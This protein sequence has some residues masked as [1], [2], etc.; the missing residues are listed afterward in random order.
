MKG[1]TLLAAVVMCWSC[2]KEAPHPATP[3]SAQPSLTLAQLDTMRQDSI[4]ALEARR[5]EDS[6][7]TAAAQ[8]A[9][10]SFQSTAAAIAVLDSLIA[11][12]PKDPET[13]QRLFELAKLKEHLV[14]FLD[15]SGRNSDDPY[16]KAHDADF[17]WDEP[18]GGFLYSGRDWERI[19]EEFP[20]SGVADTA[21]WILAHE[22][23]GGEC[24]MDFWCYYDGGT[25]HLFE[26]LRGFP[27]SSYAPRAEKEIVANLRYVLDSLP[28]EMKEAGDRSSV[29]AT[30][31]SMIAKFETSTSGLAPGIRNVLTPVTD[32]L[33]KHFG[34]RPAHD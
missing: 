3:P 21:G 20:A 9:S 26:F 13:P 16:V 7:G 10:D 22:A 32:S 31:D 14:I 17:F 4:Y 23:R 18:G 2:K 25:K 24:E 5:R 15:R 30:A 11:A 29:S 33:R 6:T 28:R 8:A 12:H 1:L 27:T 19:V 34:L